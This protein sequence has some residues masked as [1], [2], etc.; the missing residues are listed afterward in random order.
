[1]PPGSYLLGLALLIV[2]APFVAEPLLRRGRARARPAAAAEPALTKDAALAAVR[3]LDFDFRTGKITEADYA[4]LRQQ[5]L[6][7]A[8]Q[9]AA[10]QAAPAPEMDDNIEAAVRAARQARRGEGRPASACPECQRP[11]RPGD[12]FCHGCGAALARHCRACGAPARAVDRFCA[13]CGAALKDTE[14]KVGIHV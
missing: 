4:P 14:E 11:V 8:A 13:R 9:A 12:Q 10:A 7:A 3:D 2:V 1:M 5:L 6:A